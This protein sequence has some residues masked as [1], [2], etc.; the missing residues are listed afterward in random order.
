MPGG[1]A[2][3]VDR[4][5]QAG[6]MTGRGLDENIERRSSAAEAHWADAEGV[7]SFEQPGFHISVKRVGIAL[8]DRAQESAF[9]E[10]G[11]GLE[12]SADSDA[13]YNWGTGFSPAVTD[14]FQDEPFH[15]V[16]S[17]AGRE[18]GE[19]AHV[20]ASAAFWAEPD[21]QLVS[22]DR[23]EMD[24]R[25]SIIA[26]IHPPE[27]V[28]DDG[29]T[30]RSIA[31]SAADG[32]LE[33]RL[34]SGSVNPDIFA[35]IDEKHGDSGVLAEGETVFERD[36]GVFDDLAEDSRGWLGGFAFARR[37]YGREHI[38]GK[39]VIGLDDEPRDDFGYGF[40]WDCFHN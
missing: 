22:R 33:S 12:I 16:A 38:G 10:D 13:G 28:A 27:R 9:G 19:A 2:L 35:L 14:G 31:V 23:A 11:A 5:R 30:Q 34:D 26:G 25:W 17:F 7:D 6:D 37:V 21:T 1:M 8:P 29:E 32:F 40:K 4:D 36:P 20:L 39:P 15:A 18:H 3:D 24:N